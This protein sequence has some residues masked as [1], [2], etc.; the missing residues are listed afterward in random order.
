MIIFNL[1]AK[2]E[3]RRRLVQDA[4]RTT[5]S[6]YLR[7]GTREEQ[8]SCLYL[9]AEPEAVWPM[10]YA[11]QF[12]AHRSSVQW[13]YEYFEPCYREH[14]EHLLSAA[15]T[16]I[17][18]ARAWAAAFEEDRFELYRKFGISL[19]S[20]IS[21]VKEP[22]VVKM[23]MV[24]IL[25]EGI[26]ALFG[27]QGRRSLERPGVDAVALLDSIAKDALEGRLRSQEHLA[28]DMPPHL[29]D[30]IAALGRSL[31]YQMMRRPVKP[32]RVNHACNIIVVWLIL[33][34]LLGVTPEN[35]ETPDKDKK[36][37]HAGLFS[38]LRRLLPKFDGAINFKLL[39]GWFD[40]R[41]LLKSV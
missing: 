13:A 11:G 15:R 17:E 27:M 34:E 23:I 20:P 2:S 22:P 9:I 14:K 12:T 38:E 8:L 18:F 30:F 32:D 10:R 36:Q 31:I 28:V 35:L 7:A 26:A 21:D 25:G 19:I 41:R 6:R 1:L 33:N 24:W 16:H 39:S 4:L 5:L 40:G 37:P 3:W 29:V